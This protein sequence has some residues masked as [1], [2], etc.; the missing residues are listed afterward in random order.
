MIDPIAM[1][2]CINLLLIVLLFQGSTSDTDLLQP[3]LS[4]ADYTEPLHNLF[5]VYI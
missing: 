3:D 1:S 5:M 2:L 4:A